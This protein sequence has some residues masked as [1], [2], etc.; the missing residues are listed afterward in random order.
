MV[1]SLNG[2]KEHNGTCYSSEKVH[3]KGKHC[4]IGDKRMI[5]VFD[6]FYGDFRNQAFAY[7]MVVLL[8]MG[9]LSL[10]TRPFFGLFYDHVFQID[11]EYFMYSA[12]NLGAFLPVILLSQYNGRRGGGK[13]ST[14]MIRIKS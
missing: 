13:L 8:D 12:E 6:W 11:L 3:Y 1:V 14:L 5:L 9:V 10:I 7:C 2:G 4:P